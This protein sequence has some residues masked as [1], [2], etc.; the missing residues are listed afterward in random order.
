MKLTQSEVETEVAELVINKTISGRI[1]RPAGIIR[2]GKVRS[3]VV[4]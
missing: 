2:F 4:C 1:D 3:K